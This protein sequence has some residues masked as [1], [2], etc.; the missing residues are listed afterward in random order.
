MRKIRI[1][2]GNGNTT[3]VV[4]NCSLT[5][6]QIGWKSVWDSGVDSYRYY[7]NGVVN[8]RFKIKKSIKK[9]SGNK[10]QLKTRSELEPIFCEVTGEKMGLRDVKDVDI[11]PAYLSFKVV[12]ISGK[13]RISL[14]KM[15]TF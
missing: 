11:T 8:S 15:K 1:M 10:R 14:I 2:T 12:S 3:I 13:K 4:L 6:K 9:N 5:G 7:S